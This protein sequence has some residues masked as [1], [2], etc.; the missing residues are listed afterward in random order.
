MLFDDDGVRT[1][2]TASWLVQIGWEAHVVGPDV[3]V[4]TGVG[5]PRLQCPGRSGAGWATIDVAELAVN[6]AGWTIV[7]LSRSPVYASGHIPGAHFVLI[8]RFVEHLPRVPGDGPV[9]LTGIDGAE[10]LL[11]VAD[12]TASTSRKGSCARRRNNGVDRKQSIPGIGSS[13]L[14]FAT[15]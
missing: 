15:R 9:V 3:I 11:A 4:A 14:G 12:A 1:R 5:M 8:S 13:F 6:S 2:M 10:A 7:D